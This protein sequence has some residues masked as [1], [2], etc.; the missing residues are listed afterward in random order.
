MSVDVA[1]L[2]PYLKKDIK[3]LEKGRAENSDLL[4]CLWCEVYSSINIAEIDDRFITHEEAEYL[5]DKYL[6]GGLRERV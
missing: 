1:N 3:A 5:R 6:R 4:D 2:P